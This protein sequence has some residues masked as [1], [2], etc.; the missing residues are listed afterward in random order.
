MSGGDDRMEEVFTFICKYHRE[1]SISPTLREINEGCYIS[2]P[3]VVRYLDKLEA[4]GRIRRT[5]KIARS[6]VLVEK[7]P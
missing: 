6:I 7:C 2:L 1:N 3:V 4:L 5:P